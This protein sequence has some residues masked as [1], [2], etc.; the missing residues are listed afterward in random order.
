MAE[1]EFP[2]LLATNVLGLLPAPALMRA[3]ILLM[4]RLGR[5][6]P[7]LFRALAAHKPCTIGI[8]PTDLRHRFVL[9]FG[10][11]PASL[12]PTSTLEQ[13]LNACVRGRLATLV[14]LLE[15]RLD[16]D[17]LFFSREVVITGDIEAIVS[18]RNALDRETVN[19]FKAATTLFGPGE[20][21]AR[22]VALM[23]ERRLTAAHQRLTMGHEALHAARREEHPVTAYCERVEAELQA[24]RTRMAKIEAQTR[25]RNPI[26]A[27]T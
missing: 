13:S 25:R 5:T 8:E 19:V 21:A 23:L 16:S 14:G 24:L 6:H 18:L 20:R 26:G 7:R 27:V 15:G 10:G 3:T 1:T 12:V 17:A 11:G 4:R 9:R 22:R 2:V